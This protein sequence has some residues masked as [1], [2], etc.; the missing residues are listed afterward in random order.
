MSSLAFASWPATLLRFAPPVSQSVDSNRRRARPHDAGQSWRSAL[1]ETRATCGA[2]VRCAPGAQTA[3]LEAVKCCGHRP[4]VPNF[5]VGEILR[6]GGPGAEIARARIAG[7]G[8]FPLGLRPTPEE[9]KQEWAAGLDGFGKHADLRCPFFAGGK[10]SVWANRPAVCA[11][12]FCE[13]SY[14]DN[15]RSF[16]MRAERYFGFVE[17]ALAVEALAQR[18]FLDDEID[19][20]WRRLP[21]AGESAP[22]GADDVRAAWLEFGE[23]RESFYLRAAEIVDALDPAA[24][25][26]HLGDEGERR[27]RDVDGVGRAILAE[28]RSAAYLALTIHAKTHDS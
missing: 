28:E 7:L 17:T 18:G 16:W 9:E 22:Y 8:A 3:F 12:Y 4:F 13:T 5:S 24:F 20:S 19:R 21:R 14:G 2:C 27:W 10:C 11:S 23:D 25:W 26:E 6:A 15:G 1:R